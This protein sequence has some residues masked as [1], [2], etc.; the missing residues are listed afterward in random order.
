MDLWNSWTRCAG[1]A[2]GL[3]FNAVPRGQ[4]SKRHS[5]KAPP[6]GQLVVLQPYVGA[7]H[8]SMTALMQAAQPCIHFSS[9]GEGHQL[10]VLLGAPTAEQV[11]ATHGCHQVKHQAVGGD[12]GRKTIQ[13]QK[14]WSQSDRNKFQCGGGINKKGLSTKT[15]QTCLDQRQVSAALRRSRGLLN[16]GHK[17]FELPQRESLRARV[18]QPSNLQLLSKA[19]LQQQAHSSL[20][21]FTPRPVA[22]LR[23][24]CSPMCNLSK[25]LP[26][27]KLCSRRPQRITVAV[28]STGSCQT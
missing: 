24:C 11:A 5:E 22:W 16:L 10:A 8:T 21:H 17:F 15:L 12:Q 9:L 28:C 23:H 2:L 26:D 14:I 18:W 1:A 13:V 27:L 6:Q 20:E 19:D 25:Q 7:P 3:S 4:G